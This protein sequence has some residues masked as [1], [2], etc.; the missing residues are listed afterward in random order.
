MPSTGSATSSPEG[1][2]Q[3]VELRKRKGVSIVWLIPLVAA[4]VAGWLIFTT[5]A[6]K[7]PTVTITFKTASGLEAEKTKIKLKDL[8]IG[9]V[10]SL[11]IATA[12]P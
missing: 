7:G 11:S 9:T 12:S 4:V 8:E 3:E 10:K 5:F 1:T 2:A 6:E